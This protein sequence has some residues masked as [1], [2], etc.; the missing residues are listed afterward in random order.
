MKL[1]TPENRI[2]YLEKEIA[3]C[4]QDITEKIIE[5]KEIES[6]TEK[7]EKENKENKENNRNYWNSLSECLTWKNKQLDLR[8]HT[9]NNWFENHSNH[10]YNY[11]YQ[12]K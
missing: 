2:K 9:L 6:N 11:I 3:F 1:N 12:I 7:W 8:E 4:Q 10:I 5:I